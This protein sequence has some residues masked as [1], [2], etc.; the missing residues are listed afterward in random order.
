MKLS[1]HKPLHNLKTNLITNSMKFN[2][3]LFSVLILVIGCSSSQNAANEKSTTDTS[4][5]LK[6]Q[7]AV[8]VDFLKKHLSALAADSMEG[9][10]TGTRG[11]EMAAE[12]LADQYRQMGLQAIGDNNSYFQNYELTG[13]RQDSVVFE[14]YRITDST[15]KQISRSVASKNSIAS[16]VRSFGGTDTLD[17]PIVFAGFGVNDPANNVENLEGTDLKDKWVLVFQ[18]IPNIVEGDTLINPQISNQTRFNAIM[19]QGAKGILLIPSASQ[20]EY[21]KVAEQTKADFGELIGMRL[22]YLDEEQQNGFSRGYNVVSPEMAARFLNAGNSGTGLKQYRDSLI[23]NIQTIRAEDL[24]FELRHIPYIGEEI[25]HTKNVLA[26]F[27]GI[28]PDL[29]DEV[30]VLT[31]HYDHVGIGQPDSTGDRIYNG[32]DDDG[33]GTV[34]LMNLAKAFIEAEKSGVKP[35]RSILFLHVSGEEKGLLGSRYYSDHPEIPIE[36][37]I[38]NLNTD[39]IG[40]IDAEHEEAGIENYAYIIGA[41]IISSQLDSL[42]KV[43]NEKSGNIELSMKYND[44][45]DPNQFYRRSDHWNFGRLGVPFAFFFTGVHEDYHRPSDE[46][47]KI[48]FEKMANIVRTM[49]ATTVLLAN[50]DNPPEVDNQEFIERTKRN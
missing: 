35:K 2:T 23:S 45:N 48:R 12:Y 11:E 26:F 17:A 41:D 15:R 40:R 38:A 27:E 39:M 44:L 18:E 13:D 21:E 50:T 29:K 14:T 5:L 30:I 4:S 49:Y 37:T 22:K 32:A 8:T 28:D 33:S 6:H 10:E 47:H 9:R 1:V 3:L 36:K 25:I 20:Q 31:S 19:S 46:V 34:A 7:D 16:Y 24:K 43:A 42:L